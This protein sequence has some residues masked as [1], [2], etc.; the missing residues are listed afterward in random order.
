MDIFEL[1]RNTVDHGWESCDSEADVDVVTRLCAHWYKHGP[2]LLK[3][4][5]DV[6][7][8]LTRKGGDGQVD[9]MTLTILGDAILEA[10][11]IEEQT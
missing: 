6:H 10:S 11:E 7:Y 3:A 5:R 2:A 4:A 9:V 1:H 8:Y